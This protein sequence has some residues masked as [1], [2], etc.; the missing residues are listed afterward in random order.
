MSLD[1]TVKAEASTAQTTEN[2]SRLKPVHFIPFFGIWKYC[3]PEKPN[4]QGI[5]DY[6][7]FDD[8]KE[9]ESFSKGIL[10]IA[11]NTVALSAAA[12]GVYLLKQW[13]K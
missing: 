9:P 7:L 8:D 13:L 4:L 3:F 10:L 2:P 11:Y 6:E 1:D 12:Y 5:Y